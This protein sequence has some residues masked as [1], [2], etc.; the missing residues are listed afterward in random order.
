M[1]ADLAVNPLSGITFLIILGFGIWQVRRMRQIQGA[2]KP[3]SLAADGDPHD[4]QD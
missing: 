4:K 2:T 3:S 1:L